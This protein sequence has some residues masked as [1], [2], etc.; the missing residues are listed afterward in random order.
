MKAFVGTDWATDMSGQ[1]DFLM[2]EL[3]SGYSYVLTALK[4]SPNTLS[5]AKSAA[6]VFVRKFERPAA[7]DIASA[8]RQEKAE[9]YWN[10]LVQQEV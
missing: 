9:E 6:D 10:Q 5:G 8:R 1:L 4:G 2:A 7:V 3:S